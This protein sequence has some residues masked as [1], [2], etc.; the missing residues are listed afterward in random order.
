MFLSLRRI[1]RPRSRLAT[2][3][4]ALRIRLG[5]LR[6]TKPIG[7]SFGIDRGGPIDRHY[8]DAFIARN[9]TDIK[10]TVL[11]AG[12]FTSYTQRF[13]D[14][15]VTRA[16]TLY[17][18]PGF[19]DGTMVG[20]LVT[21]VG[22]PSV[23]FDCLIMTQVFPFIYDL[24][25]AVANCHRSLKAGGVLL[26]TMPGISQVSAYDKENWGD[27]WRFTDGA[28]ARL[29]GDVFGAANV[30]VET[31]GNVLAACAFLHGLSAKD[32]STRE[33]DYHDDRF[34]LSISV[35]AVK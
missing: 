14:Q 25:A 35:R 31:Y 3:S 15:R 30:Q 24:Q 4:D 9:R 28:V 8:I 6:R 7:Q 26:A 11:E 16:E 13:G 12:G 23:S 19:P 17:P 2:A 10:G 27:Y 29:F 18:K 21:G 20:D 22:I 33:L 5:L 34:Q 32:L 1:L